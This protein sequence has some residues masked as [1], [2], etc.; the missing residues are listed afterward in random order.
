MGGRWEE[1]GG[2][3]AGGWCETH[4]RND[5]KMQRETSAGLSLPSPFS[6]S[7]S[8]SLDLF[9]PPSLLPLMCF[10]SGW[11]AQRREPHC[12]SRTA[13]LGSV[14]L[15]SSTFQTRSCQNTQ[16]GV[17][18]RLCARDRRR[19]FGASA[20][21]P[22]LRQFS[23]TRQPTSVDLLRLELLL[24]ALLLFVSLDFC[25]TLGFVLGCCCFF[26]F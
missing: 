6:L 3:G 7:I 2:R 19:R 23:V 10:Q 24:R 20:R 9:L 12:K 18:A 5:E 22:T 1:E 4:Q 26:Q 13:Q 21:N 14:R 17:R 15:S 16:E 25:G 11:W 8:P